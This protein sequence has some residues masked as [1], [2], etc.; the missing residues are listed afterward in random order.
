MFFNF[1]YLTPLYYAV[2]AGSEICTTFLLN[3]G[4]DPK[5]FDKVF[6]SFFGKTHNGIL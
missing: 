3:Y 1:F 4:A 2:T 6:I 5:V